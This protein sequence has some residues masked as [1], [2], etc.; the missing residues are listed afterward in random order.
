M[1]QGHQSRSRLERWCDD[2][3]ALLESVQPR[4]IPVALDTRTLLV[5]TDGSWEN[6]IAGIGAVILDESPGRNLVIQDEIGAELLRLW[7]DL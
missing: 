5:F 6:G 4:T 1:D 2:V 3:T 7:G